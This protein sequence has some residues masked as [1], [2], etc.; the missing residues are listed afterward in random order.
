M[1][2]PTAVASGPA[3]ETPD[4][5]HRLRIALAVG[6]LAAL[7]LLVL[8][9]AAPVPTSM[10]AYYG[11]ASND[12]ERYGGLEMVWTPPPGMPA[13]EVVA[14]FRVGDDRAQVRRDNDAFVIGVPRVRRDDVTETA[15]RLGGEHGL[16][17]HR[18]LQ[19]DE[20]K[21]LAQLLQLPMNGQR[22]VDLEIDQWR[23]ELSG[24]TQTD[25]YLIGDTR[26]VIEAKLADARERGWKLPSGAR[27]AYERI[28]G[29]EG[30]VFRTYVI[31]ERAE[32]GGESIENAMKSYDPN[33]NRPIVLLDFD[34][35]S[36]ARFGEVTSQ[37]VGKKLAIMIGND[38]RSAPI[39]NGP[40]TG[41][42][43]SIAMG[44]ND[45]AVQAHEAELLVNTLRVGV[46]PQGGKIVSARYAEPVDETAT[47]WLARGTLALGGG[48]LIALLAWI[49]IRVTQPV[50]RAAPPRIDGPRPWRRVLVTALAPVAVYVVSQLTAL[51]ISTDEL[52]YQY[53]GT[54]SGDSF[55]QML[56]SISFGALGVTPAINAFIFVEVLA[57]II[58]GWR[59][60]RHAGPEA[61]APLTGA[62]AMTAATLLVLQSWFI[63]QYLYAYGDA[64]PFGVW[65]RV[66]VIGS[67]AV[68]TLA[69]VGVAAL[70]RKHGLG[71]GYGALIASGW[72]VS[73][74]KAWLDGPLL[75]GDVVVGGMTVL[76]I[77]IPFVVVAR[78]RIARL[79]EA[80]LRLPSSGVA[81]LGEAGGL[82]ILIAVLSTFPAEDLTLK[83]YDW[84]LLVRTHHGILI[85]LLAALTIVW[86]FA[87]ARPSVTRTLAERVGVVA[88]ARAT[89]WAA[90]MLSG[91]LL[92]L[93][94]AVAFTTA[95]ARPSSTWLFVDAMTLAIVTMVALDLRADW[96]ARRVTLERVWSLHQAQ[97]AD[98]VSRALDDAGI[99]H[100][101]SST[102]LKTLL[103]F[104]GPFTPID[105]LV[106]PEHASA[107]R[108]R[109]R[110]LYA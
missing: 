22:P 18:V 30:V 41:G 59:R 72:L 69:L 96:L 29:P 65:P 58:P 34:D 106:P 5:V 19:L 36:A 100:H 31:D 86:S 39:I 54:A 63:T 17:F 45:P 4:A 35:K 104:F 61:R 109:L 107:A 11:G 50:R 88:P 40:I 91:A 105:V 37:I 7:Y 77:A 73:V 24:S 9:L 42:R 92:L 57:L 103:A 32:L 101:L 47:R 13:E 51:G 8:F 1:T 64:L 25:Y 75:D 87:F 6:L 90:T 66:L 21:Q 94:G 95:A 80:P 83:L 89:W 110:E 68:G 14:R 43:A 46:L 82:A 71:N 97:H 78:W 3:A 44:G 27:I 84:S 108:Q 33:T 67:F 60:R 26:E 98:L 93:V 28:D 99:P 12:L 76:A 15:K 49:V 23:P 56:E 48:A 81:P 20:M 53:G 10:L 79:G 102:H 74:V 70:I 2:L 85:A 55:E 38:V 16:E 52:L 62:V